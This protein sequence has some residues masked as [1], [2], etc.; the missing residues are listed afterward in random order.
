MKEILQDMQKVSLAMFRKNY[1]GI[2]HGSISTRTDGD[3]FLINTSE[4]IFDNL[5]E[6]SFIELYHKKDYR[7][8]KASM[9]AFIHSLLYQNIPGAKYI[10]CGMPPYTMVYTLSNNFI[11]PKDYF[12]HRYLGTLEVYNLKDYDNWYDR[13]DVEINHY[14][15]KSGKKIMI[16]RGYGVY[17]YHRDLQNLSKLIAI[18]ENSC[19]LLYLNTVLKSGY[20][21]HDL[22]DI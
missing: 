18:L 8:N 4:A 10:T 6:E 14:F 16:I 1:F 9:D 19:R 2:F 22:M 15:K 17:V 11:T 21:A 12:G 3:R 13:A 20:Y 7:W 5:S